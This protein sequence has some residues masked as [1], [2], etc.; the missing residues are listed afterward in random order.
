MY[1]RIEKLLA[2]HNVTAYKVAK[3]T[4]ISKAA[5]TEWKKGRNEPKLNTLR[6]LAK[7]FNVPLDYFL[8]DVA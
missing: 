4:G 8:S 7:Y 1:Q 6:K 3:E 5:F 2:E